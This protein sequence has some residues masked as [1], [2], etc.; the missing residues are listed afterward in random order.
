MQNNLFISVLF[1][2][3]HV[4]HQIVHKLLTL[5]DILGDLSLVLQADGVVRHLEDEASLGVVVLGGEPHLHRVLQIQPLSS[6]LKLLPA[7]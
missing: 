2:R 7:L 1:F 6:S 3:R 4:S 5:L